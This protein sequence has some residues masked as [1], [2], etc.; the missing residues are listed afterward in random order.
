MS[1]ENRVELTPEQDVANRLQVKIDCISTKYCVIPRHVANV[2]T[3]TLRIDGH[4][5]DIRECLVLGMWGTES[6]YIAMCTI[7]RPRL[8]NNII[9]FGHKCNSASRNSTRSPTRSPEEVARFSSVVMKRVAMY[10]KLLNTPVNMPRSQN[11]YGSN[12]QVLGLAGHLI[13]QDPVE[14]LRALGEEVTDDLTPGEKDM[15]E[16]REHHYISTIQTADAMLNYYLYHPDGTVSMFKHTME[17]NELIGK[18]CNARR[19]SNKGKQSNATMGAKYQ[20]MRG[21]LDFYSTLIDKGYKL[22]ISKDGSVSFLVGTQAGN[23]GSSAFEP[24]NEYAVTEV[25]IATYF[26]ALKNEI[27]G[28]FT[29]EH[30]VDVMDILHPLKMFPPEK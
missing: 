6:G 12:I 9:T 1:H 19:S 18:R 20:P 10:K 8:C 13:V 28:L 27:N 15:L 23:D 24:Q 17:M 25:L 4:D 14:H 2:V 30:L 29:E 22:H 3:K 16:N 7:D 11:T 26:A 21:G 5:P